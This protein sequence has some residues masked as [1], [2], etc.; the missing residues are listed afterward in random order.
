MNPTQFYVS[1]AVLPTVTILA[2]L[3]GLLVNNYQINARL[4]DLR[5]DINTRFAEIGARFNQIDDRFRDIDSR[6]SEL[7]A[8]ITETNANTG[9]RI[10][11]MSSRMDDLHDS[12]R[13]EMSKNQSELLARFDEV[14]RRV[15]RLETQPK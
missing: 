11:E 8:R 4:T 10:N 14:E 5:A 7:S 13:T 1:V 12:L 3:I 2:V 15:T 9:V 6:I